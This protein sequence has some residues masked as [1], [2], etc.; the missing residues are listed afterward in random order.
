MTQARVFFERALTL[1]PDNIEALVGAARVESALGSN[2]FSN[3]R[4]AH[5]A[6]AETALIK[7]QSIAFGI[8]HRPDFY[9]PRDPRHR[10]MRAGV[11]V[12]SQFSYRARFRRFRQVYSRSRR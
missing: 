3:D 7:A 12:G 4:I 5:L 1:D 2:L 8:G 10:R 6:A 11:G 9:E